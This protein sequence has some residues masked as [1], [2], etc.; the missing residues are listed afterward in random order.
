MP[1][2]I[3][4]LADLTS[5][6]MWVLLLLIGVLSLYRVIRS[7]EDVGRSVSRT[8]LANPFAGPLQTISPRFR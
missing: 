6:L 8:I 1:N 7:S 2:I 5:S 3:R 4:I